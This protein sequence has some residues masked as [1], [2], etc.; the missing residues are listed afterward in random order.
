MSSS[1]TLNGKSL[2]LPDFIHVGPPRTGTTW[3]H[4][5][6]KGHVGLPEGKSTRFFETEY[7]R[8]IKWYA[9]FFKD[10]PSNLLCGEIQ[11][12]TFSN[13]V[14]RSRIREHIPNCKILCTVRDPAERLYSQY[15][16][17]LRGRRRVAGTS[18]FD[19][20]WWPLVHWGSDLCN[21]ATQIRRWQ[22]AFSKEQ[23]L[24]LFYDE[25]ESDPQSYLNKVCDFI[26]SGRIQ[27][28]KSSVGSDKVFS[29]WAR[30]RDNSMARYGLDA[31]KWLA[32]HGAKPLLRR[33]RQ[34]RI[35]NLTH[36]LLIEEYEPLS[37][38]S[39]EQ[40]R[41]MMLPETEELERMTGRDLSRWKPAAS[42][43]SGDSKDAREEMRAS[44]S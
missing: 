3:L 12:H 35:G 9:D 15:R 42:R 36:N 13:A 38:S 40:V 5:V 20:Y 32:D 21:Y 18:G 19:A 4:E 1:E 6:L 25:L 31:L 11:A 30:A 10:Y 27:I 17:L 41:H 28:Q 22:E 24:V 7:H 39:A 23:V 14:A 37:E 26:G 29:V 34:T 16:F 43:D 8:G 33:G 2:R 44:T